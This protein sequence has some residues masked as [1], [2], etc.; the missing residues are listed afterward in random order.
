MKKRWL[1]FLEE[2]T[3]KYITFAVAKQNENENEKTVSYK[4]KTYQGNKNYC[5]FCLSVIA[6]VS[7][8]SKNIIQG[9]FYQRGVDWQK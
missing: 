4:K 5:A 2:N 9:G 3:E 1:Q 8:L 6:S 7:L